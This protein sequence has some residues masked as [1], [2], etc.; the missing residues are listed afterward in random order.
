MGVG[1]KFGLGLLQSAIVFTDL[2]CNSFAFTLSVYYFGMM[3]FGITVFRGIVMG[4]M[5]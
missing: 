1:L 4:L 5:A 2:Y 3:V